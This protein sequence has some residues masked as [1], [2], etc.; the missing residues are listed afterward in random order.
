M[1]SADGSVNRPPRKPIR[2][3]FILISAAVISLAALIL[4]PGALGYG[5]IAVLTAPGCGGD[6]TP[7]LMI[8]EDVSFPAAEFS[9]TGVMT[10]AY[11]IRGS[12]PRNGATVIVM[13]TG[14]AGRGDR[15]GEIALFQAAG[16]DVLTYASRACLQPINATLG[17]REAA[18][19]GDALAYL[20]ERGN[21]DMA[22]VGLFGF[23]AGGAAAAL[24]AAQYP[25]IRA[26][27]IAGGYDDFGESL[28]DN[29]RSLGILGLPYEWGG[30]L[31]YRLTTGGDLSVLSPVNAL[32]QIAPRPVLLAYGTQEPSFEGAQ[33]MAAANPLHVQ[34][35]AVEG[36]THGAYLT[37]QPDAYTLALWAFMDSTLNAI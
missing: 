6:S 23:S 2:I 32:P 26:V 7:S 9:D 16:Y 37:A 17:W 4:I 15:M 28:R 11:F 8:Y 33:R 12:E 31:A 30:R 24:A 3:R 21:V 29:S 18:Q 5:F 36:A 25:D 22:R 1:Q 14:S 34:F 27:V 20:R 19:V 10:P 35:F 13:P